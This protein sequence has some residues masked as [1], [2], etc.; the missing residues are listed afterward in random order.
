MFVPRLLSKSTSASLISYNLRN[1]SKSKWNSSRG[2]T[3]SSIS[4]KGGEESELHKELFK[5]LDLNKTND[6]VFWGK[7]GGSGPVKSF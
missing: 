2:M 5:E 3:Q 7:W 4:P 6:G 1:L